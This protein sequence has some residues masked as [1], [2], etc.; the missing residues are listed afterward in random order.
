MTLLSASALGKKSVYKAFYD[1]TLLYPIPRAPKRLELG[2]EA[3]LPF[4]GCDR[5]QHYE[6]SWLNAKGKP[7]VAMAE[8]VYDCTSPAII[9]SKSMKLYFNSLNNSHFERW[10]QVKAVL[11][12]DL[13]LAVGSAVTVTLQSLA[14]A[15]L[16]VN[17]L[18]GL[19][20]DDLDIACDTY[21]VNPDFL[22]TDMTIVEQESLYSDLLKSNCLVTGQPDWGS[23]AICY[24]GKKIN[25][26]GLLRYIVSFRDHLEFHEQCIERIY[27][28]IM[29]R[30][31]PNFLSVA[32]YYTR[33]GGL[34]INPFRTSCST[35][36][37]NH[38]RLCRQ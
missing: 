1:A 28:D 4:Y 20:L 17:A 9:E 22:I 11:E 14:D 27:R 19:S 8:I 21:Q 13:S 29:S 33:R 24:S 38:Q 7:I 10:D 35:G 16:I 34:D 31:Q 5:W 36:A 26:A 25:P 30:C 12:H 18:S 23:V 6:V 3:A 15:A 32:G 37:F 2:I